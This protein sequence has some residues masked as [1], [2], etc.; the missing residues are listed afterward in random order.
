MKFREAQIIKVIAFYNL[1]KRDVYACAEICMKSTRDFEMTSVV[2]FLIAKCVQ[3]SN[4]KR[5]LLE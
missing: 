2:H 4:M 1:F 5:E 3:F